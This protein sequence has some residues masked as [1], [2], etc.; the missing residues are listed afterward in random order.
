MS[1]NIIDL[2]VSRTGYESDLISDLIE[3][4]PD[5]LGENE[6]I[7]IAEVKNNEFLGLSGISFTDN[8]DFTYTL[9]GLF[10]ID[11]FPNVSMTFRDFEKEE[12]VTITGWPPSDSR[13]KDMYQFNLDPR[14]EKDFSVT[15]EYKVSALSA[16][17]PIGPVT[18]SPYFY[19][20]SLDKYIRTIEYVFTKTASN[21]TGELFGSRLTDYLAQNGT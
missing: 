21:K 12:D 20:S 10:D 2:G 9:S 15:V 19:D 14:T 1:N 6:T 4:P 16:D 7:E 3:F 17:S 18:Q 5:E 13:A 8:E 11:V